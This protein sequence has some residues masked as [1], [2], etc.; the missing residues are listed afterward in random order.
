LD[1]EPGLAER[2]IAAAEE[3]AK[4]AAAENSATQAEGILKQEKGQ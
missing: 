1:V 4:K 2:I 3:S